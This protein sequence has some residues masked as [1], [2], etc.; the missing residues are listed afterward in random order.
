MYLYNVN[1]DEKN[2]AALIKSRILQKDPNAD[3]ILF[4]SHA[5]GEAK[6]D[7]DWDILIL[8]N[9]PHV[10]RLKEKEFRDELF[11]IEVENGEVIS[12]FVF[13]KSEWNNKY[14]ATPLHHNITRDGIRL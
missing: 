7:S 5:R 1:N 6:R 4:G 8:L 13:S 10:T 14:S 3:V 2:I 9:Q 11:D 12:T